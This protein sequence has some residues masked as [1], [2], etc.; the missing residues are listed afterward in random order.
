MHWKRVIWADSGNLKLWNNSVPTW[1]T[2]KQL[3]T[4]TKQII[5]N[6]GIDTS[7]MSELS[8][9]G[10]TDEFTYKTGLRE[11]IEN[12][13]QNIKTC[14]RSTLLIIKYKLNNYHRTFCWVSNT[15]SV[16]VNSR[17]LS[18]VTWHTTNNYVHWHIGACVKEIIQ[19][20]K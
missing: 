12:L 9:K 13:L 20:R 17:V 7:G 2:A 18:V 3:Q 19:R 8:R 10:I 6:T 1:L 4:S 16:T 11:R 15:N 14:K 5:S